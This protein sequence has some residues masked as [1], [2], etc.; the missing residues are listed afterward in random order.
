MPKTSYYYLRVRA[1]RRHRGLAGGNG[2]N[3]AFFYKMKQV[4]FVSGCLT[5]CLDAYA[6]APTPL[7]LRPGFLNWKAAAMGIAAFDTVARP[8][9]TQIPGRVAY[10]GPYVL[11]VSGLG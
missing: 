2:L 4:L 9:T 8:G 11:F 3:S 10:L 7:P 5:W 1:T 6:Q